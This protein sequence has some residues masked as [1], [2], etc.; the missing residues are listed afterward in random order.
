MVSDV[1]LHP[2]TKGYLV[3]GGAEGNVRFFD[4]KLRLTAWFDGIEAGAVRSVSFASPAM[5]DDYG[6][7]PTKEF[8]CAD[9]VIAT[10]EQKVLALRASQ[11]EEVGIM[12]P[13][14]LAEPVLEGTPDAVTA[15]APHPS[16]AEVACC[17]AGGSV[18]TW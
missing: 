5:F 6:A 11:F 9:F 18:W 7:E 16:K 15:I 3:S 14:S 12:D 8:S 2:Y 17:G 10:E 4:A 13:S 1:N